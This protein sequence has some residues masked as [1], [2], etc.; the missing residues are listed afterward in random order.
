MEENRYIMSL[1]AQRIAM[2]VFFLS[3]HFHINLRIILPITSMSL[4]RLCY[5]NSQCKLLKQRWELQCICKA[6]AKDIT[7]LPKKLTWFAPPG[8]SEHP[9]ASEFRKDRWEFPNQ[10]KTLP[11]INKRWTSQ[12]HSLTWIH[13]FISP[14]SLSLFI[15]FFILFYFIVLARQGQG[16]SVPGRANSVIC[17]AP[18]RL[19]CK[20]VNSFICCKG[21]EN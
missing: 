18:T 2:T 3:F 13:L 21:N 10:E 9:R 20:T 8:V 7:K 11:N 1:G 12:A 16:N 19:S 17:K 5:S 6:K 14:V 4:L 15:M